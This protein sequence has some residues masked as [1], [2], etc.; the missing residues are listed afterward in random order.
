LAKVKAEERKE[1]IKVEGEKAV[2]KAVKIYVVD[3]WEKDRD[4]LWNIAKKRTIYADPWKWKRI[5][6]ANRDKI[7][8]ADLIY[9]GQKLIIP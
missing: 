5:Y 9:P 1:Q 3:T 4:C 2:E 7:K 6:K 8:D